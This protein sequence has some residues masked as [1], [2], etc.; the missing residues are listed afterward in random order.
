M[1]HFLPDQESLHAVG[2]YKSS[3][4]EH[5]ERHYVDVV[6]Y[7]PEGPSGNT[8]AWTAD[9]IKSLGNPKELEL[10]LG[11]VLFLCRARPFWCCSSWFGQRDFS[12]VDSI[13]KEPGVLAHGAPLESIRDSLASDEKRAHRA[14]LIIDETHI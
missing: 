2:R 4:N 3:I 13:L 12:V 1:L 6:I 10:D 8:T 11:L 5:I 7:A 9:Q 14:T